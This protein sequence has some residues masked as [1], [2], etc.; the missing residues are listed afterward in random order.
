MFSCQ[1]TKVGKN[2]KRIRSEL[3]FEYLQPVKGYLFSTQQDAAWTFPR[4]KA[5]GNKKPSVLAHGSFLSLRGS[6]R[7]AY[8]NWGSNVSWL[9]SFFLSESRMLD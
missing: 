9:Y 3:F 5:G 4:I 8:D 2:K 7:M 6:L 1:R